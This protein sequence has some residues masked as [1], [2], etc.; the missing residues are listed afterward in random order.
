MKNH[1]SRSTRKLSILLFLLVTAVSY[2]TNAQMLTTEVRPLSADSLELPPPPPPMRPDSTTIISNFIAAETK[3]RETM[4]QFSFKRDVTLRTVDDAGRVT[5]EYLR[6]SSFVLDDRGQRIE[7]LF[8]HPPST[9]KSM[10]ITKE[11]I[12]DLAGSQ[13]FGLEP[14]EMDAYNFACLGEERLQGQAVYAIAVSPRQTPD[15]HKMRARFFVGKIWIDAQSFHIVKLEGI[16]EPHGKQRFPVFQTRRDQ[17]IEGLPFPSATAADDVL[18]FPQVDIRYRIAVRYY[19]FKRFA[20][21]VK[22]VDVN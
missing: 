15:P 20:S 7:Q 1:R 17:R 11:D 19:D 22:I 8:F 4:L 6:S 12:Q 21:R 2:P 9:I 18:H 13:L 16:T 3:F 14:E 5:G 10:K